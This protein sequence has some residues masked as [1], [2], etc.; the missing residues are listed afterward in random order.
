M[1]AGYLLSRFMDKGLLNG[2]SEVVMEMRGA[3]DLGPLERSLV[4]PRY[5]G[6]GRA[7]E[8][9]TNIVLPFFWALGEYQPWPT[10]AEAAMELFRAFPK[11]RDNH[12]TQ[13]M[14]SQ[15]FQDGGRVTV[16][17]ADVSRA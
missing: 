6:H 10:L 5:L 3:V 17:S 4:V 11:G 13:Q 1:G 8:M 7:K 12:I 9:I 14:G 16:D 15:L 2:L